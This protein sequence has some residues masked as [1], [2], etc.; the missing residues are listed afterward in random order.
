MTQR[1]WLQPS[2]RL[3]SGQGKFGRDRPTQW[4]KV[5]LPGLVSCVCSPT[6]AGAGSSH[7]QNH[8]AARRP[9]T[10]LWHT[11]VTTHPPASPAPR[12]F[13][14]GSVLAKAQADSLPLPSPL[15]RLIGH[16]AREQV[17]RAAPISSFG[18]TQR[19]P[20]PAYPS[21]PN[22][23]QCPTADCQPMFA[24][25]FFCPRVSLQLTGCSW[26]AHAW[27][28]WQIWAGL[29]WTTIQLP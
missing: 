8:V 26:I 25:S 21:I 10:R 1:D 7:I 29:R 23:A 14:T 3:R 6:P 19:S 13:P 11:P 24:P 12:F 15:S 20:H 2:S 16:C 4:W 27:P 5:S 18:R 9:R 17:R 22:G 28:R